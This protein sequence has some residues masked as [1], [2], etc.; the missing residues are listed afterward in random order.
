ME[1]R[2]FLK[3][4]SAVA[5]ATA[6]PT[7]V[8]AQAGGLN[9][10]IT[11]IKRRKVRLVRTLGTNPQRNPQPP[12]VSRVGGNEFIEIHTNQGLIGVGPAASAGAV[13][14][15]KALL[16]GKDPM[17]IDEHAYNLF[18]P[19]NGGAALEIALWDLIGK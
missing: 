3:G 2:T 14:R 10:K 16:V 7:E 6:L 17:L 4:V 1:R 9:L 13:A 18:A 19:E 5:A 8:M 15:G 12:A 11:D